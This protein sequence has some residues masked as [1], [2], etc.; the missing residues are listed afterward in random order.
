VNVSHLMFAAAVMMGA[1][2]VALAVA[3]K[4]E[5]GS[6]ASHQQHVCR[7]ARSPT[8]EALVHATGLLSM[9]FDEIAYVI[10]DAEPQAA[11]QLAQ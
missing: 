1:T 2:V 3:K 11:A 10:S 6:I 9:P 8:D 7:G 5:L 4:L